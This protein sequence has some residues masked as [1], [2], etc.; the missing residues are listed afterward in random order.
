MA[1]ARNIKPSFFSN[2]GL[3]KLPPLTRLLFIGLWC[4][5][6]REGRLDDDP[7]QIKLKVLPSPVDKDDVD[8]MLNLLAEAEFI[9][10]Y[11]VKDVKYI[12]IVNFKKHQNPHKKERASTIP[13]QV[14]H[15][16]VRV[17]A[18]GKALPEPEQAPGLSGASPENTGTGP[19]DPGFLI[20]DSKEN[21]R[22]PELPAG[23]SGLVAPAP[24]PDVEE[25]KLSPVMFELPL[26]TGE[27][28]PIREVWLR[29]L[30]ALFPAVDV[31][32][33]LRNMRAWCD[34]KPKRRKTARGVK[35]F[36]TGW[37][38]KCQDKGECR[39]ADPAPGANGA[40]PKPPQDPRI[41]LAFAA[42][43]SIKTDLRLNMT[44]PSMTD[45]IDKAALDVALTAVGGFETLKALGERERLAIG[46]QFLR[47]YMGALAKQGNEPLPSPA[48]APSPKGEN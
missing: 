13:P 23:A 12:Q 14:V 47:A 30:E 2:G 25:I 17:K 11:S 45:E 36:V 19:A 18:P 24:P 44:K 7:F 31:P 29:D 20:P 32:Q 1:R 16:S 48:A 43:D 9:E 46:Q 41:K 6:D 39:R 5:A 8:A 4:I 38:T 10:R 35:G 22:S 3:C 42:W 34:S 40:A 15:K 26:N 33:A 37:L 21:T 28:W 27:L